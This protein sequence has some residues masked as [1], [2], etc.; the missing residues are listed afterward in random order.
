MKFSCVKSNFER[1]LTI[2]ER[3]TGKNITLPVLGNVLLSVSGNT[4]TVSA[5][6]LEYAVEVAVSGKGGK[7]GRVS[8][9]AKIA[10]SLLQSIGEEK[11][12]LEG[13]QG[14]LLVRT[15]GR[16][17]RI[18]GVPA[19]DF[20]LLPNIKKAHSLKVEGTVLKKEVERVLPAVSPSDFKPELGGVQFAIAGGVLRLAATDTFRLAEAVLPLPERVGKDPFSF[21]LPLRTSQEVAR[22][23]GE[24]EEVETHLGENQAEFVTDSLRVVSRLI[25]GRFPD[26]TAIIPKK[27]ATSSF[28][29]RKNFYDAVR[30][31]SIFASKLQEV[32]LGVSGGKMSVSSSN[33]EVGEYHTELPAPTTG[34]NTEASFNYRYLLDGIN[35][36]EGEDFFLGVNGR[37]GPALVREKSGDG[38]LYVLMPIRLT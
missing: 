36:L 23:F 21:I 22:V 26:Y 4:L 17:T 20:P 25:E 1:A 32:H 18:N 29:N 11:V 35:A 14:S 28:L 12:E 16:D 9:P 5:T 24:D 13:K 30:A 8:V 38:F 10:S 2:A 37:E 6:N 15:E 34:G 33:S 7:D 27:F 3:F 31:A 19:E